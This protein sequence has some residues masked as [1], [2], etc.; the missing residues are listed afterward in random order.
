MIY[1]VAFLAGLT[2][3]AAAFYIWY[4]H[5]VAKLQKQEAEVRARSDHLD[6]CDRSLQ[7][8]V[9]QLDVQ[10]QRLV[11]AVASHDAKKVQYDDLLRENGH[12]KQ[13]LFRFAVQIRKC[14]RDHAALGGSQAQANQKAGL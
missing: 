4:I 1:I 14:E 12:L 8:G 6:A 10:K 5:K 11:A 2:G 9:A 7:E 13:D 3:G